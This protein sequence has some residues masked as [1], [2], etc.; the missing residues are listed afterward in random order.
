MY[1]I[2]QKSKQCAEVQRFSFFLTWIACFQFENWLTLIRYQIHKYRHHIHQVPPNQVLNKHSLSPLSLVNIWKHL[3]ILV[4]IVFIRIWFETR[5]IQ[6]PSL[7]FMHHWLDL[8]TFNFCIPK[9]ILLLGVF[10][11][12]IKSISG[13]E[14]LNLLW[15]ELSKSTSSTSC[16]MVFTTFRVA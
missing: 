16:Q 6:F 7:G 9:L 10:D 11:L 4:Y 2:F 15:Q 12:D 13:D 5:Q 8:K 1:F 3:A 14:D